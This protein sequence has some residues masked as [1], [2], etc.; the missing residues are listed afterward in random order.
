MTG[1][2]WTVVLVI[3]FYL[4]VKL[5]HSLIKPKKLKLH[6]MTPPRDLGYRHPEVLP[7]VKKLKRS[8]RPEFISKVKARVLANHPHW[9]DHD[10]DWR[11]FE[12]KRYFILNKILNSVP[13]FSEEVDE[14][15]H[16]MLM[17]TKDY[18]AFS[19]EFYGSFLHHNP[20]MEVV[21]IP[22]DRAFF[23]WMYLQLFEPTPNSR[24]L[25]GRF[26]Q[27]PLETSLLDDFRV[28]S[29]DILLEKYFH[30]GDRDEKLKRSLVQLFQKDLS[31]ADTIQ[32]SNSLAPFKPLSSDANYSY[33]LTAMVFYS[34]YHP[35]NYLEEIGALMPKEAASGYSSTSGCSSFACSSYNDHHDG[36]GGS[37]SS[38]SGSSSS[39]GSGCGGGCSS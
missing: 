20:T 35:D 17:F 32:R 5:V 2:I 26:L 9:T 29:E 27:H 33:L 37:D 4:A 31:E 38:C 12:L 7:L 36:G 15:W 19:K 3:A 22:H 34:V 30:S 8:L 21:P 11:L 16:E 13:M 25:W 23:D 14:I 10:F 28:E 6:S 39:C 1:F 24:I 18:E